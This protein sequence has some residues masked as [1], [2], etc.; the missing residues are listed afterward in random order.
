MATRIKSKAN[1]K[2][3]SSHQCYHRRIWILSLSHLIKTQCRGISTTLNPRAS[4]GT[5]FRSC[6][7]SIHSNSPITR[8]PTWLPQRVVMITG[9]LNNL[10]LYGSQS[11]LYHHHHRECSRPHSPSLLT[12]RHCFSALTPRLRFIPLILRHCQAPLTHIINIG[13]VISKQIAH[14][15]LSPYTVP[16][17]PPTLVTL[18]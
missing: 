12:L 1:Q 4:F 17:N 13:A 18:N 16:H 14:L 5:E 3:K 7:I 6:N 15:F 2:W 9:I 11:L 8:D 10:R